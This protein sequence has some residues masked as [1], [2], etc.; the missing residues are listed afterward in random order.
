MIGNLLSVLAFSLLAVL[1]GWRYFHRYRIQ[2]PPI[3]VVNLWD[4]AFMMGGIVIVPY[5]YLFLPAWLVGGLLGVAALGVLSFTLGAVIHRPVW[6]WLPVLALGLADLLA[7]RFAGAHSRTSF[8]ANNTVQVLMVAGIANLWAQSGLKARDAAILGVALTIYDVIFTAYLP[9]MGDLF[10]RLDG[11]PFAPLV[12]WSWGEDQWL[13][14]GVGD[15]LLATVFPLVMRKAYG[16]RA[17]GV[18]LVLAIGALLAVFS[19]PL[20]ELLRAP[21]PA[22]VV[23]GPL[24]AVQVVIWRRGQGS[25]R[26]MWQ[27][28]ANQP[29]DQPLA[30]A[31]TGLGR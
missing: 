1:L 18:A 6:I 4:V 13:A 7:L 3:G 14:I 22:M 12:G 25:E 31:E 24:M 26:K 10:A 5:L 27:P 28:T 9:L 21:F 16:Q 19:L 17:G 23:L 15:L 8:A 29:A 2:R 30:E 11:L 20:L